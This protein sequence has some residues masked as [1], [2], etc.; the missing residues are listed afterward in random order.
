MARRSGR[1]KQSSL[2][3]KVVQALRT[4]SDVAVDYNVYDLGC[5]YALDV[6]DDGCVAVRLTLTERGHPRELAFVGEVRGLLQE[7]DGVND[8]Q[9][10]LVWDPAWSA[11]RISDQARANLAVSG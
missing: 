2:H 8:V 11:A 5:I 7:I 10:N 4:I 1:S 9:V 3:R 6:R